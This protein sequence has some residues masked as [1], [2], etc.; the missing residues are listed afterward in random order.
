MRSL[1]QNMQFCPHAQKSFVTE[2]Q[3][4]HALDDLVPHHT[5]ASVATLLRK[6]FGYIFIKYLWFEI[7]AAIFLNSGNH[8]MGH[9]V[10]TR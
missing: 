10:Y 9:Y 1:C 3:T 8:V 4:F 7:A 6:G 5:S 2:L